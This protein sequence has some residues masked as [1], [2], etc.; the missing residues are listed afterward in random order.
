MIA[1][2]RDATLADVD[3][4]FPRLRDVDLLEIRAL[5][6]SGNEKAALASSVSK[7]D[8]CRVGSWRGVP[9][10][11]VGVNTGPDGFGIPWAVGTPLMESLSRIL[12]VDGREYVEAWRRMYP[13]L[14]NFVHTNNK[15]SIRWLKRIGFTI[16]DPKPVGVEAQLFHP[17][18]IEQPCALTP[19]QQL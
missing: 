2:Y 8:L 6:G 5:V 4:F 16:C 7:A 18:F 10:W 12:L 15:K 17:F 1:D 9:F 13:A 11:I 3:H 19:E 14:L